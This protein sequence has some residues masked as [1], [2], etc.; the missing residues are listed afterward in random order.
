MPTDNIITV[1]ELNSRIR[2]LLEGEVGTLWVSGEISN[3]TAAAS[4]HWYFKLKDANAQI[5]C[6]MFR[7]R[8]GRST[9]EPAN[10]MKV[11]IFG[12][13]TLYPA[14]G[15]CQIVVE[16]IQESGTGNLY[17]QFLKLKALLEAEGLFDPARKRPL[18]AHPRTIGII[19]SLAAAALQDV[20]STLARRNSAIELIL[21]PTPVQGEGAGLQIAQAIRTAGQRQECDCLILCRGGGSQEDLQ[22]FNEE[23]VA[24]A[25][26][27]CPIPLVSG[28]GHETDFTIADFVADQRA[29]T[30][31]A[32]AELLS[33]DSSQMKLQVKNLERQIN[34]RMMRLME[35]WQMRIDQLQPRFS[36]VQNHRL[37]LAHSRLQT[38]SHRL[39]H[40][41][42]KLKQTRLW[43]NQWQL[44][45]H[46]TIH[47]QLNT[48]T[49]ALNTLSAG[50]GHLNPEAVLWRGFSI[51]RNARGEIVR[52]AHQLAEGESVDLKFG[53]GS[54]A[55]TISSR[56]PS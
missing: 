41:G 46:Q 51:V 24:R 54:A 47:R 27:E 35:Q 50:L 36:Q 55:A 10:G 5:S 12:T 18:P 9:V 23:I 33:P 49:D 22:S 7:Q 38:L 39:V 52:E 8:N 34:L 25:I 4:G 3:F 31:T 13:V 48:Q 26:A 14:R 11:D 15:E 17:Q 21:Y 44:R 45:L 29:P 6:A 30:P 28:V 40:P 20:L 1:S 37:Q 32:A 19:T 42:D 53:S 56:Q 16:Q 43:L 2:N